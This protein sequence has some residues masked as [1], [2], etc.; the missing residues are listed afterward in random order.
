MEIEIL[1]QNGSEDSKVLLADGVFN[2][3]FNQD[4]VHQLVN[5][6]T[7][8]LVDCQSQNF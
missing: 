1:N 3:E 6:L 4:L 7:H 5:T 2:Q 8:I